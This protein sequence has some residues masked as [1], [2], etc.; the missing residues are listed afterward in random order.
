MNNTNASRFI[1]K[2]TGPVL[3]AMGA[4]MLL[5]G[6]IFHPM[7]EEFLASYAFIYL[8]GL[9][10]LPLGIAVL[11]VHNV[12]APDWRVIITLLGWLAMIG[13][14]FRIVYPQLVQRVGGVIFHL[15]AAPP[16]GGTVLVVLGGT[17]SYF[18]YRNKV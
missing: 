13:G 14:V 1:A 4:G 9:L 16:L 6:A 2:L 5:N 12:W 18:G 3:L 10:V 15:S 8:S 11:L 17:L 7:T